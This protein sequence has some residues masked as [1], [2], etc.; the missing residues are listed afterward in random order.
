MPFAIRK[1]VRS[2]EPYMPGKP[3]EE[4]KR[5][6]G[7][8][9][10]VKLASNE[11]PLGPS[12]K[13]VEAAQRAAASM[14]LYPDAS[15][16]QVKHA[17]AEFHDVEPDQIMLGNGSD[18]L[19]H[20]LGLAFLGSPSDRVLVGRPTFVRYSA[21]AKL[22]EARLDEVPLDEEWKHDAAAMTKAIEQE[23]KLV[24]IANPNNP[25]GTLTP[26]DGLREIADALPAGSALVLDEAYCHF[27]SCCDEYLDGLVLL[28]E[29]F[30][31]VLFRTFSKAYGLAGIRVGYGIASSEI[32]SAID[33]LREPFNVNSLAQAAA[34]AALSD[35]THI[36][37]T[38]RNNRCGIQR[39]HCI[40]SSLGLHSLPS[41]ANFVCIDLQTDA[42]PI[43]RALL[44][45]GIIV[46]SGTALGMQNFIR[47]SVGKDEEL[48]LFE[49]AFREVMA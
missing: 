21:A 13:A 6:F 4:V 9:R 34:I 35:E 29:G 27:A 14:H 28:R 10:V 15:C 42:E 36:T 46:R 43:C 23:T 5:E 17:L 32:V 44:Q 11:N 38:V 24:F 3:I 40:A 12:P 26:A 41:A 47:V 16:A 8:D 39:L 1:A 20:L 31:V 18:D 33:A 37:R 25:T 7:L 22:G 48:S 45:R 2:L 49:T 19:I 30:P